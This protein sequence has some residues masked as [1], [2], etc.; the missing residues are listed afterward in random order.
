M[1]VKTLPIVAAGG[2]AGITL[3]RSSAVRRRVRRSADTVGFLAYVTAV[4]RH[5]PDAELIRSVSKAAPRYEAL[6][7]RIPGPARCA[8]GH[9]HDRMPARE[10]VSARARS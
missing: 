7:G 6:V 4:N 10:A 2:I 5:L 3:A 8:D 9:N 1:L